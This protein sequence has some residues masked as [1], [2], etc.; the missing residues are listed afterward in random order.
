MNPNPNPKEVRVCGVVVAYWSE[1]RAA[2]LVT[3]V[4][5]VATITRVSAFG[6]RPR[7]PRG[8][9]PPVLA[10]AVG[11]V[12]AGA[13]KPTTGRTRSSATDPVDLACAGGWD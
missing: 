9:T 4:I 8:H 12:A 7:M 3:G 10:M 5:D 1:S 2:V 6:T 13:G 11:V